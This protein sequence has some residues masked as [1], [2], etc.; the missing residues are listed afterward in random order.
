MSAEEANGYCDVSDL[1]IGDLRLPAAVS[2]LKYI[3]SAAE[4]MDSRIG[5]VYR[6]PVT[7]DPDKR[8]AYVATI[9]FLRSINARLA[10]GRIIMA[11]ASFMELNSVHAY[12]KNL[13]DGAMKDL[14]Q[15]ESRQRILQGAEPNNNP[16]EEVGGQFTGT[17]IFNLDPVSAVDS[18]YGFVDPRMG[19]V[20]KPAFFWERHA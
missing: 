7:I 14:E 4:E 9:T 18:F 8:Q 2:V 13:V 11:V 17:A 20:N 19:Q 1:L 5:N 15:I 12:A 10:S 16:T 3:E 6:V